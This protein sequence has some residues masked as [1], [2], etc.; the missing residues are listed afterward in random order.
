M[1]Q[2]SPDVATDERRSAERYKSA[3]E[4]KHV[5]PQ[6]IHDHDADYRARGDARARLWMLFEHSAGLPAEQALLDGLGQLREKISSMLIPV[7]RRNS[8]KK[9]RCQ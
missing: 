8:W 7:A 5:G 1:R 6:R 2:L 3:A 9:S 4:P